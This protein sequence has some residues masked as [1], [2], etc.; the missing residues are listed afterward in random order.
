MVLFEVKQDTIECYF[1]IREP[2]VAQPKYGA[3]P[4]QCCCSKSLT[5]SPLLP[6]YDGMD[7][8]SLQ[9]NHIAAPVRGILD[10]KVP[11]CS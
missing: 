9:K 8:A 2:E 1:G 4:C 10:L 5:L 3:N 7:S 11:F 6:S